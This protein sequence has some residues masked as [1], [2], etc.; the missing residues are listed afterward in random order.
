MRFRHSIVYT[1]S[2]DRL[3]NLI[4]ERLKEGADQETIDRRIWDLFGE[5]WCVMATD[6]VGFSRGVEEFGIIHFLQM[7]FEAERILVPI[8]ERHDGILL[9]VEGDTF[10]VIFRNPLKALQAAIEMQNELR[11][12]NENRNAAD[13]VLLGIG[14]G[15]GQVLRIGDADVFGREVNSAYILGEDTAG[16]Y[17]ILITGAMRDALGETELR[18]DPIELKKPCAGGAFRSR[19]GPL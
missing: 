4:A 6:L 8:L 1:A 5:T 14:L 18:F 11:G 19:L 12:Y 16:A 3:Q 10:L 13:Q 2:E 17:E 9:K 7:M 15:Y